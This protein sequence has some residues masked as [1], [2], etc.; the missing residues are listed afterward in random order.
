MGWVQVNHLLHN[1]TSNSPPKQIS[2]KLST[3]RGIT[4][5]TVV[6]TDRGGGRNE[7]SRPA[8]KKLCLVDSFPDPTLVSVRN[9]NTYTARHKDKN[10]FALILLTNKCGNSIWLNFKFPN[11]TGLHHNAG[12]NSMGNLLKPNF[13]HY[14]GYVKPHPDFHSM[15]WHPLMPS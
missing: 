14:I 10:N 8:G 2:S 15:L 11:N 13:M 1:P 7:P 5:K 4:D 12:Q 3:E 9:L 6:I